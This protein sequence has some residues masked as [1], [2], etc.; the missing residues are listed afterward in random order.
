MPTVGGVRTQPLQ[1][2]I[3]RIHRRR[4]FR[5]AAAY[6][7][8]SPGIR[9]HVI[10][11]Q[12]LGGRAKRGMAS[13]CSTPNACTA[14]QPSAPITAGAWNQ[15]IRSTRSAAQQRGG[16]LGAALDQQPG[17]PGVGRAPHSAWARSTP[18]SAPAT[19]ISRT[20]RSAKASA[21][22][23]VGAVADQHPGRGFGARWRPGA[24]AERR[25][26]MAVGH[27]AHQPASGRKPGMRQVR[28]GSSASTVPTPTITASCRPR[29]ACAARRA[30]SPV[31][32]RLSPA[33]VAMRPSSVEASF[34][35]TSGRRLRTRDGEAGGDLVGFGSAA[36]LP[37]PRCRRRAAGRGRRRSRAGRGRG[38]RSTTR[39][40]PA[41]IRA[42]VQGG[43]LAPVAA[44][45]QRHIGGRRR[46]RPGP[47]WPSARG[48]GVRAAAGGGDGAADHAAVAAR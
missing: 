23:G 41:A 34:S 5:T 14:G 26:Q 33:P 3:G 43:V 13:S 2:R 6:A 15:A 46:A 29:S 27:D 22:V 45:L 8:S 24:S 17:E 40:T 42:S 37:R 25:A 36:R 9:Q 20:P 47:P 39:A 30:G 7:C 16:E 12:R 44:G 4:S 10:A 1:V 11:E 21:T 32:Q 31:I 18:A 38:W 35:V 28:S 48:L 19:S